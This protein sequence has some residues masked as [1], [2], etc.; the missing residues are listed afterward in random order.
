MDAAVYDAIVGR[1]EAQG[2][3]VERLNR[4]LQ[5]IGG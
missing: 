5:R 4:T 2:Y 1:L 3:E